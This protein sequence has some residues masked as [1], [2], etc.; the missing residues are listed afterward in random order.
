[1]TQVS[2]SVPDRCIA[3]P[4][5]SG[6]GADSIRPSNRA[7][8]MLSGLSTESVHSF[9]AS[10]RS[11]ES[12]ATLTCSDCVLCSMPARSS[13]GGRLPGC[14]TPRARDGNRHPL[15]ARAAQLFARASFAHLPFQE[16][17]EP[18]SACWTEVDDT[19]L[20]RAS[21]RVLQLQPLRLW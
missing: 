14:P 4:H 20:I 7:L 19:G 9:T 16:S 15:H 18:S 2:V 13:F 8:P 10:S 11:F 1:M 12:N 6:S 17:F 5:T 21:L 3:T